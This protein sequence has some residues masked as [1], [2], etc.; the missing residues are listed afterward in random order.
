MPDDGV[1]STAS[2]DEAASFRDIVR[3]EFNRMGGF[4]PVLERIPDL[5]KRQALLEELAD[6][7]TGIP[8]RGTEDR[9]LKGFFSYCRLKLDTLPNPAELEDFFLS[10]ILAHVG[11][12]PQRGQDVNEP[13]PAQPATAAP[14]VTTPT[15]IPKNNGAEAPRSAPRAR[16]KEAGE[17]GRPGSIYLFAGGTGISS[18]PSN[19][20]RYLLPCPDQ[21]DPIARARWLSGEIAAPDGLAVSFSMSGM[22]D[23]DAML[24]AEAEMTGEP[25]AFLAR[26]GIITVQKDV[27]L[28][29]FGAILNQLASRIEPVGPERAMEALRDAMA[30][31]LRIYRPD[32]VAEM[33]RVGARLVAGPKALRAAALVI[34][35]EDQF[36]ADLS[37]QD[38]ENK[39]AQN[40]LGFPDP[41]KALCRGTTLAHAMAKHLATGRQPLDAMVDSLAETRLAQLLRQVDAVQERQLMTVFDTV[42]LSDCLSGEEGYSIAKNYDDLEPAL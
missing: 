36:L 7:F 5:A 26:H 6:R 37:P 33:E 4:L 39:P 1:S 42:F 35:A 29:G 23:E 2:A 14:S 28:K 25:E 20:A 19:F 17:A 8:I 18:L 11:A 12:G 32:C 21:R 15:A 34:A 13:A 40:L 41:A 31:A 38:E 30:S 27:Y 22:S 24:E 10:T 3:D 9:H 16:S